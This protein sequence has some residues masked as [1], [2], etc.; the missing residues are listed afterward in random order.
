MCS[1]DLNADLSR[2]VVGFSSTSVDVGVKEIQEILCDASANSDKI[3]FSFK[4]GAASAQIP[5]TATL[6]HVAATLNALVIAAGGLPANTVAVTVTNAGAGHQ[7][8][9]CG[10][11]QVKGMPEPIHVTFDQ[12]TS[13]NLA[14]TGD[15]PQLVVVVAVGNSVVRVTEVQ[16]GVA[17]SSKTVAIG[18]KEIQEIGRAHV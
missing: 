8:S 3:T 5:V 4:G 7:T 18:M 14:A 1:S 15:M 11:S 16:K 17:P 6:A 9:I 12:V 10:S 13:V 2:I